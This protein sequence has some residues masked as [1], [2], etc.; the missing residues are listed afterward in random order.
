MNH[1][2]LLIVVSL[3]CVACA[4]TA[5]TTSNQPVEAPATIR[6]E[7]HTTAPRPDGGDNPRLRPAPRPKAPPEGT[8]WPTASGQLGGATSAT[9][10]MPTTGEELVE[11]RRPFLNHPEFR[12]AWITRFDWAGRGG[13]GEFDAEAAKEKIVS[14][15][16]TAKDL[17]LNAVVFQVR[18]DA[19]T[20]YPSTLE[21]W[22]QLVGGKD[23][24][25][26]PCKF[27]IEEAHKRG[28]E[29]H[30]YINPI[31]VTEERTT[32]PA[33]ADHVFFKHCMPG[34]QPNWL[35]H[36][37]GKVAPSSGYKWLNPN[38]PEVQTYLRHVVL[39]LV[40]RYDI[41]GVHYDRIRLPSPDVSDDQWSKARFA[42]EGNPNGLAYQEWQTENISRLIADLYGHIMEIKPE[43]KVTAAVWGIYNNQVL[44]QGTDHATG[45]SWTSSGLQDYAQDSVR[46][47]NEGSM[48]AL[49]PMIYWS[50]G[51]MKP[52]YD[53]LLQAFMNSIHNGR[54]VYG[55]Q[56]VFSKEEM[57]RQTVAT[58]L[59][60]A[61]GTVPFTLRSI[62]REGMAEY[63]KQNINPT[64]AKVP[65]MPW[66][67]NPVAG[68]VIVTVL[69]PAGKPVTDAHVKLSGRDYTYV[70]TTEGTCAILTVKPG[71]ASIEA[72]VK[73]VEVPSGKVDVTAG[74]VAR[75]TMQVAN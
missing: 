37:D 34:S 53:E 45:Y 58:N 2:R 16:Q 26:D 7:G 11:W 23:P 39:D 57:L 4:I 52:D 33:S 59:I 28:L 29:F 63:Y 60:G 54:H 55:G 74:K 27:A 47:A 8:V 36:K 46:W 13:D 41:D 70:T 72:K 6:T 10:E 18:G 68:H 20:L 61:Q 69:D 19:T 56:S 30:A 67:S 31:P 51:D 15:M 14:F 32:V 17:R 1:F 40:K 25:F 75:L 3:A 71:T 42:G 49:I 38:L 50:M 65:D 24:G 9:Q 12:G 66:K 35:V 44:P 62:S 73:G 21:P 64:E 43:V 48:D 5:Q 22:S